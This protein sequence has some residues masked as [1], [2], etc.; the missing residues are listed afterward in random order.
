MNR[1]IRLAE[2]NA[3]KLA[4][5]IARAA[6]D[7]NAQNIT[8]LD[9]TG[10]DT[11]TDF[12]IIC[13]GEVNQQVRAIVNHVE[14]E[15]RKQLRER[16]IHREGYEALNWVLLDYV[17]VVVHVFRPSFREYYRLEDLWSDAGRIDIK[18]E[19]DLKAITSP[20][21]KKATRTRE[22]KSKLSAAESRSSS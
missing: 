18:S 8:V 7:K 20:V 15:M 1:R 17:D 10:L 3:G 22:R 14:K 2:R 4:A 13:T 5:G 19:K 11:V 6:L 16:V 12:F 21:R 9:L